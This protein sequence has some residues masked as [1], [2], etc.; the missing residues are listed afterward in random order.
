MRRLLA[1]DAWFLTALAVL[2]AA[3]VIYAAWQHR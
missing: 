1:G 2:L 3:A